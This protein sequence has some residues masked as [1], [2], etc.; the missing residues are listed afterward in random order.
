M[1]RTSPVSRQPLAAGL[2]NGERDAE[3]GEHRHALVQQDV[4]G[5]D[6]AMDDAE[7]VRMPERGG[8]LTA[9]PHRLIDR[10]LSLLRSRSRKD[11]PWTSGMA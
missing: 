7:T 11:P 9:D 3:V 6:V 5:L 10:K 8:D 1:P 4:L 2:S